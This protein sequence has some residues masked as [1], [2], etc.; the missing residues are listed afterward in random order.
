ME[1]RFIDNGEPGPKDQVWLAIDGQ[2]VLPLQNI[3]GGNVQA[4]YDQPHKK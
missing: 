3:T 4:H 2:V 1:F